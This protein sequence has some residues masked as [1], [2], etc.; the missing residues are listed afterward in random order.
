MPAKI[1]PSILAADFRNLAAE[2]RACEEA[3][4][5]CLHFDVM[6][7]RFVPNISFGA[8]LVEALRPESRARFETHLMIV[9]PERYVLDFVKAGSDLVT[10]HYEATTHV[11]RTLAQIREGGARAGLALN[12]ATPLDFIDYLLEDIDLLLIMTVNPGFGGQILIPASFRKV[13]EARR[14]IAESG[15]LIEIEVDGG[16]GTD[17]AWP[18][19][20]SGADVFVAGT[21]VFKHPGGPAA[22][23][24]AIRAQIEGG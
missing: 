7:G 12:P 21:S 11:Q 5:E 4:A 14:R 9:E 15:L 20:K 8:M 6:D 18:L 19:A 24:R 16:V 22:G 10:V 13:E 3:G 2:A 23:I 1:A 17:N